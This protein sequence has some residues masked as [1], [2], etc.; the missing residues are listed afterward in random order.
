MEQGTLKI[1]QF[2]AENAKLRKQISSLRKQSVLVPILREKLSNLTKDLEY[3]E[4]LWDEGV[5]QRGGNPVYM[6]GQE[7]LNAAMKNPKKA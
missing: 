6:H 1:N 4:S 3:H 2:Q 7:T 5:L